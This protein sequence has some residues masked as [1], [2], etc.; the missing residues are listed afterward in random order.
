MR[1]R[2]DAPVQFGEASR[3]EMVGQPVERDAVFTELV[4][5]ARGGNDCYFIAG[6]C[7]PQRD[8]VR[9]IGNSA[10]LGRI[11]TSDYLPVGHAVQITP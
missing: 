1:V 7:K 2:I 10:P 3:A 8:Q 9:I 6:P 5:G 4:S 11:F